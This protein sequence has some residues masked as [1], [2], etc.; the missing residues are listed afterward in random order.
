MAQFVLKFFIRGG[1]ARHRD[2]VCN[3]RNL[4]DKHLPDYT[5]DVIDVAEEPELA[6]LE[7]ILATPALIKME[8]APARRI[9]G[10]VTTEKRFLDELGV[11]DVS[12]DPMNGSI[13]DSPVRPEIGQSRYRN[14]VVPED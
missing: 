4:C 3:L 12:I 1:N 5:L 13:M 14:A 7:R 9:V 10:G 8:P 2:A 11:F 6:K